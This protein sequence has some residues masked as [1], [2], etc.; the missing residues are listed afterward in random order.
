MRRVQANL[1]YFATANQ[2]ATKPLM[3]KVPPFPAILEPIPAIPGNAMPPG[4]LERIKS[5]Y[6]TLRPLFPSYNPRPQ[7]ATASA[8][9]AAGN[10]PSTAPQQSNAG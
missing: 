6:Q 4:S 8:Q 1:A 2:R 7:V 3:T 9:S 10:P 5:V